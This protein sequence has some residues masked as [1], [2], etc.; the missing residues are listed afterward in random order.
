MFRGFGGLKMVP[1]VIIV[2]DDNKKLREKL[3]H[4]SRYLCPTPSITLN[5]LLLYLI[6]KKIY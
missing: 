1:E 3:I 2:I 5:F 4:E 6:P